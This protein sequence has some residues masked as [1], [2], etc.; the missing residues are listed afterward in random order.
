MA[1]YNSRYTGE[2]IDAKHGAHIFDSNTNEL[3]HF[4]SKREKDEYVETSDVGLVLGRT[5]FD[6]QGTQYKVFIENLMGNTALYYTKNTPSFDISINF[7]LAT[8][9]ITDPTWTKIDGARFNVTVQADYSNKGVWTDISTINTPNETFSIKLETARFTVGNNRVRI[10]ISDVEGRAEDTITYLINMTSMYLQD[11]GVEWNKV[12]RST[13]KQLS[14]GLFKIGGAIN[15]SF[16]MRISGNGIDRTY[17]Q[18]I[19]QQQ[20]T[21]NGTSILFTNWEY[22]T[23]TADSPTKANGTYDVEFWLEANSVHSEHLRYRM[24]FI[25]DVSTKAICINEVK[26]VNNDESSTLFAFSIY[27]GGSSSKVTPTVAI[28]YNGKNIIT[29]EN[30]SVYTETKV[31]FSASVSVVS[32]DLEFVLDAI[33]SLDTTI[34]TAQ[35]AVDNTMSFPA[36]PNNMRFFLN[37]ASRSN[38]DS[39]RDVIINEAPYATASTYNTKISKVSFVDGTDGWTTDDKEEN[40]LILQAG[41]QMEIEGY[42]PLAKGVGDVYQGSIEFVYKIVNPSNDKEPIISILDDSGNGIKIAAK[43]IT[44]KSSENVSTDTQDYRPYADERLHVMITF[45]KNYLGSGENFVV[46]YVNGCMMREFKYSNSASFNTSQSDSKA[47]GHILIG[48]TAADVYLYKMRVYSEA[49]ER[50][51]VIGNYL[52]SLPTREDKIEEYARINAIADNNVIDYT[53]CVNSGL[54]TMVIEMLDGGKLPSL[55]NQGG[56]VCNLNINIRQKTDDGQLL[57]DTEIDEGMAALLKGKDI[58]N[59]TIE[60]QGTTAMTY[61]RWNFRWKLDKNYSKRRITAKKNFA[62]SMHSHKMGATRM[63]NLMHEALCNLPD[64]DELKINQYKADAKVA[65]TQYPVYGFEKTANNEYTFIGLYTVG[66]DKGDK[67]TFGYNNDVIHLEGSDHNAAIVGMEYPWTD[68]TIAYGEVGSQDNISYSIGAIVGN[69]QELNGVTN[70][71]ELGACND[72]EEDDIAGVNA[73]L[74][75]DFK[76]AYLVAYEN[77]PYIRYISSGD[78]T[79][80]LNAPEDWRN[81]GDNSKYEFIDDNYNL[82]YYNRQFKAYRSIALSTNDKAAATGSTKEEQI[83]NL[84]KF[85]KKR[86]KSKWGTYWEVNDSI[87]HYAFCQLIGATDNFKKNT[88]PYKFVNGKWCWR[89]DDLDTIFDID[90]TGVSSKKY[91][92]LVGDKVGN[93]SIYKGIDSVFWTLVKETQAEKIE[94]MTIK[95]LSIIA[96]L[97]NGNNT[98]DSLVKGIRKLFWDNAQLY[99]PP[100]AYN[101]DAYWSYELSYIN[102]WYSTPNPLQQSLGSHYETEMDWIAQ[103]MVFISSMLGYGAFANVTGYEDQSLGRLTYR[104]G[105]AFNFRLT[106]AIDMRPTLMIGTNKSNQYSDR[107]YAGNEIVLNQENLS[108]LNTQVYLTGLDYYKSIGNL[109][110]LVI[111]EQKSVDG[112]STELSLIIAS[113]KRLEE[114]L[115]CGNAGEVTSN[116]N[117]V[118]LGDCPSL[119][120]FDA[121]NSKLAGELDLQHCPRTQ[122][123]YL[124]GTKVTSVQLPKGSKVQLLHL[125]ESATAVNFVGLQYLTDYVIPNLSGIQ[126]LTV[127]DC[128]NIGIEL[129]M[130]ILSQETN[131]LSSVDITFDTYNGDS[132]TL[133]NLKALIDKLA[134]EDGKKPIKMVGTLNISGNY[135]QSELDAIIEAVGGELDIRATGE[136]YVEFADPVVKSLVASKWGN[137]VGIT[138]A[139]MLAVTSLGMTFR[140]NTEITSFDELEQFENVMDLTTSN[141]N[142]LGVF[143]GCSN[144]RSIRMPKNLRTIQANTFRDCTNL[145]IEVEFPQ[146][147]IGD[148]NF[149]IPSG[150]FANS[151]VV[152]VKNLGNAKQTALNNYNTNG[153]FYNCSKLTDVQLPN[154]EVIEQYAFEGCINLVNVEFPATITKIGYHAFYGCTKLVI[155]SA[156]SLPNL[157]TLSAGAFATVSIPTVTNLGKIKQLTANTSTYDDNHKTFGTSLESLTLPSSLETLGQNSVRGYTTLTKVVIPDDNKIVEIGY[158]A[159]YGCYNLSF[160]FLKLPKLSSLSHSAFNE[161]GI[162]ELA[163]D[164]L[165][166]ILGD[167]TY[168]YYGR[169]D[170]L[171]KVSFAS[172]TFVQN[173]AFYNCTVLEEAN[174]PNV[175]GF[176]Q[177]AFRNCGSLQSINVN[178]GNITTISAYAFYGCSKLKF[179]HL[180]LESLISIGGYAFYNV[181]IEKLTLGKIEN[182]SSNLYLN[183]VK[184]VVFTETL[185]TLTSRGFFDSASLEKITLP[186]TVESIPSECFSS[187]ERLS[188]INSENVGEAIIYAQQ[189]GS[190][191]FAYSGIQTAILPN[192]VTISDGGNFRGAFGQCTKL[193]TV[194]VGKNCT[195]IGSYFL[196]YT[197]N[198]EFICLAVNPPTLAS[199]IRYAA[200]SG[201][202]FTIYVPDASLSSYR[203]AE[204]WSSYTIRGINEL[205]TGTRDKVK[206]YLS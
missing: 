107:V 111:E 12:I 26:K 62:S 159:F 166:N 190:Q 14:I 169:K 133:S 3:L 178:W 70:S 31:P 51:N 197:N 137:G 45:A 129:L 183:E 18:N 46:I 104:G 16:K 58:I 174:I 80:M 93:D 96:S 130:S 83:N 2:E 124:T 177:S 4:G 199:T 116:I 47:K 108:G 156:L 127:T 148:E 99:F 146:T 162:D 118:I 167:P 17:E 28:E 135:Y 44:V 56:G 181:E 204:N 29:N 160:V 81:S 184:E 114:F 189:L 13:D 109:A 36:Q 84:I 144:L 48:G 180:N 164:S 61:G 43:E 53:T 69:T 200:S 113:A 121:R 196:S 176:A 72:L 85:R 117:K 115:I 20:F 182:I 145:A 110:N 6:F 165:L 120:L 95:M 66:A 153:A 161:V 188:T 5:R 132:T 97:G 122:R 106:P 186:A 37:A 138:K 206:N 94:K 1:K 50:G 25:H 147:F 34:E 77:S 102:R 33:V 52:N 141:N 11:A 173:Y 202:T 63:F 19:G 163:F 170:V 55:V 35:I 41:S 71:W 49:V 30:L 123:V 179:E 73:Q 194:L 187:C 136:Q 82:W 142:S 89:Q 193:S 195:S 192:V 128:N 21:E 79:T 168:N 23:T 59:Q 151:G 143:Y 155:N 119:E 149:T 86:F 87:F 76:P 172:A 67:E 158:S 140:G 201:T 139:Q 42:K 191:C 100:N 198:V 38:N 54:N 90:N 40:C 60:G 8:K 24:M 78:K 9:A 185:R 10:K 65:V 98:Q 75:N 126:T 112:Q 57:V 203:G 171:K 64:G 22:P 74:N 103:R 157:L 88:Y 101:N 175:T 105:E 68:D 205:P 15:K 125:S 39:N 92:I 131:S 7:Y 134:E 32:P 152:K 91:S 154:F 150:V 27:N